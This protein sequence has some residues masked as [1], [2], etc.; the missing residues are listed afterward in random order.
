MFVASSNFQVERDYDREAKDDYES[1]RDGSFTLGE[2]MTSSPRTQHN[3]SYKT[4]NEHD[5]STRA[6]SVK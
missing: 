4:H 6:D 3:G 5:A 1:D 2:D